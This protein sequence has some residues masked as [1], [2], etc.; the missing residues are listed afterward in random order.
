MEAITDSTSQWWR[1]EFQCS[2][3]SLYMAEDFPGFLLYLPA[4]FL[5]SY[6]MLLTVTV[7]GSH[8]SCD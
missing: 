8:S 3:A 2:K 4:S 6:H 7:A 5:Q 1:G